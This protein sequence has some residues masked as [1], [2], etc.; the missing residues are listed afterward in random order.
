MMV[1][2][3]YVQPASSDRGFFVVSSWCIV[4]DE[5]GADLGIDWMENLVKGTLL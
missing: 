3:G 2:R 1:F 4:V 5:W